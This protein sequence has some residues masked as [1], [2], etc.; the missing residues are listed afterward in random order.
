MQALQ[1]CQEPWLN[2]E[3]TLRQDNFFLSLVAVRPSWTLSESLKKGS[4]SWP[5]E[6]KVA[7]P[8]IYSCSECSRTNSS[9]TFMLLHQ[10]TLIWLLVSDPT[11]LQGASSQFENSVNSTNRCLVWMEASQRAAGIMRAARCGDQWTRHPKKS[12]GSIL[13]ECTTFTKSFHFCPYIS[14]SRKRKC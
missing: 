4:L 2:F 14:L 11:C 1:R 9:P 7:S 8:Q 12:S 13:S 3:K 6:D 10:L 5:R